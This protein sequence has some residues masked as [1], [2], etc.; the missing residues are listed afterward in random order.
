MLPPW[1]SALR[2]TTTR[3][4][5]KGC[6]LEAAASRQRAKCGCGV[7]WNRR[8]AKF[9]GVH[10]LDLHFPATF[11]ADQSEI[12]F[13]GLKGEFSEVRVLCVAR[14]LRCACCMLT[15]AC[16]V[17]LPAALERTTCAR[18]PPMR[19][20]AVCTRHAATLRQMRARSASAARSRQCT[21]RGRCLA[22]TRCQTCRAAAGTCH[23]I[24]VL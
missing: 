17:R 6:C 10:S 21:R 11:G 20:A 13:V 4:Q 7:S 18:M 15:L 23:D 12:Q 22:I 9:N 8:V 24:S 5:R 1:H 14:M 19:A 2:C 16:A 3:Q